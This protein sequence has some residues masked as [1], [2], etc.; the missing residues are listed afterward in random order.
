MD[1]QAILSG[2]AGG[3]S[4]QAAADQAGVEP[5]QAQALLQGVLEH[6]GGGGGLEGL[7][8]AAAGRAGVDPGV[9]QQFLP[10]VMGLL[11]NHAAQAPDAAQGP[12]GELMGSLQGSPLAGLLGGAAAGQGGEGGLLGEALGAAKGLFG[13]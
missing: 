13:S 10:M 2:L 8:E 11:Q 7:V 5:G 1:I 12:L 9:A 4:L 6:V 3:G